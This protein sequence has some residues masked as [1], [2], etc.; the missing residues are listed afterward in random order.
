MPVLS[1]LATIAAITAAGSGIAGT[2]LAGKGQSQQ[3]KALSIEEQIAQQQMGDKQK[4]FDQLQPFF[5]QYMQ[6]G[7]PF[8]GQQQ[9]AGAEQ[10]AQQF[11]NAAG[12][13]RGQM[14][15]S[16]L[17]YGPSGTTAAAMSGLGTQAAQQGSSTYLQNL[18]NNENL[19]FQAAQGL[20]GIGQMAGQ[21]QNQPNV[22]VQLPAQS[23]GGSALGLSQI[24]SA[25]LKPQTNT[26]VP[27]IT[28]LP[29]PPSSTWQSTTIS[30]PLPGMPG[31][32]GAPTTG[33]YEGWGN[34]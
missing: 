5:S 29:M 13:V 1:T 28:G 16:G 20:Q 17:G 21:G 15:T 25:I 23:V 12:Q 2:V 31:S 27:S 10:N 8:L 33:G 32:G 26:G 6:Q 22:G 19:K 3:N 30:P 34:W 4:I 9:R 24:L 11:S 14:Q 7:S 18:L